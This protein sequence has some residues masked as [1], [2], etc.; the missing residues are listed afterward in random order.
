ME[1]RTPEEELEYR[2]Y[3]RKRIRMRKRRRQVMLARAIVILVGMVLIFFVFYGIGKVTGPIGGGKDEVA[4]VTS[5]QPKSTPLNVEVPEGYE[6]IYQKLLKLKEEHPEIEDVLLNLRN[7]PKDVLRM[8][9]R[10]EETIS[11]VSNYLMHVDDET[12]SGTITEDELNQTIPLFLQWDERWGYVRYS[13]NIIAINGC[14]PT[15]MSMI[16]TGLTGNT[17]MTPAD[18]ADFC[19]E[20]NYYTKDSGTSWALM[21]DGAQRLGLNAEKISVSEEV[22][23]EK[24]EAGQPLICS[25]KPGDF[26]NTG[27]FI[28]IHGMTDEGKLLINDPN[29]IARSQK[30]WDFTT[31]LE[32][33][34]AVWTYTYAG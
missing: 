23:K 25:M 16:Y 31:V 32:Q 30:E 33:I 9:I 22:I 20:Q 15:C 34:K 27:H 2:R 26:T 19:V 12:V 7:Y 5:E 29:S 28:V 21:L 17:D 11:F 10:N 1:R 24:L 4:P 18:I 3:L 14:G 13:D 8:A 6:K